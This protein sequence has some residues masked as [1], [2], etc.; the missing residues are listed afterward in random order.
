MLIM[1]PFISNSFCSIWSKHFLA[2]KVSRKFNFT[3]D[4]SFYRSKLPGLY[5]NTGKNLTKGINYEFDSLCGKEEK[6]KTFLIYDVIDFSDQKEV[7]KNSPM[8]L[9]AVRQ[10]PG[11]LIELE[12]YGSLNEFMSKTFKKSSRYKLRKYK[13][14]LEESFDISFKAY[15]GEI[16][17][18][19]F[20]SIF[21]S[22][23]TLLEKRFEEKKI[24][25]NNLDPKEWN[26][27][28]E[29]AYPMILEK[30]AIL[31]ALYNN[32]EAIGVTLA[33]LSDNRV[34]DAITVFDIDYAKFHLGSIKIMN[35]IDWCTKNG[36]KSLDF[37]KGYFDYKTR[38]SNKKYD[39]HYH[40]VYDKKSIR[41]RML[42]FTLKNLFTF[43]QYL[44]EKKLNESLHRLTFA[45]KNHK[46]ETL[47]HSFL[48]WDNQ[49]SHSKLLPID[50]SSPKYAHIKGICYEFLY[51]YQ[52]KLKNLSVY[53]VDNTEKVFLLM[54]QNNKM[55]LKLST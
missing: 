16:T 3:K 50:I 20:N 21:D 46:K 48:E 5:I 1:N 40:I 6:G 34:F 33:Y 52:E 30:K 9:Y 44:R 51:L 19:E 35:L 36:W 43:K 55:G 10:Y 24:T 38:W 49:L 25:N 8:G 31:F 7:V 41:A 37:S 39:F 2:G 28:K 13:K 23:R 26:F 42:S 12:P 11:F 54:G 14:R 45:L 18:E 29:V 4:L 47:E 22:F 53:R 32:D 17:K 15:H 27:Y